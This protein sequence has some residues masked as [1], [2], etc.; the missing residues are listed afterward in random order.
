VKSVTENVF[1]DVVVTRS[2]SFAIYTAIFVIFVISLGLLLFFGHYA[3][4]KKQSKVWLI[5]RLRFG[6]C[7]WTEV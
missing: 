2:V 5:C 6:W 4:E 3:N 1:D 7:S